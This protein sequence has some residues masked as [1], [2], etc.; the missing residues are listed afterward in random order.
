ML[1][2]LQAEAYHDRANWPPH[3]TE[4]QIVEC[5]W[6]DVAAGLG[7]CSGGWFYGGDV[8]GETA[9]EFG[10]VFIVSILEPMAGLN[11][12]CSLKLHGTR[13]TLTK[14]SVPLVRNPSLIIV[15]GSCQ[16]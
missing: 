12:D 13:S 3:G 4:T 8:W 14:T 10:A 15:A 6:R 2:E 1:S 5:G 7:R 9:E 11:A 16:A